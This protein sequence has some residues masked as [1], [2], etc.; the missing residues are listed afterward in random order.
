M[1]RCCI[2]GWFVTGDAELCM[3]LFVLSKFLLDVGHISLVFLVVREQVETFVAC[4]VEAL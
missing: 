3:T 1:L 4:D 2:V